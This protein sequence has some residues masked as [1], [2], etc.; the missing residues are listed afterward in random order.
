[1]MS[2]LAFKI[3]KMYPDIE[4]LVINRAF[5]GIKELGNT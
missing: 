2:V 4:Y 3:M 1:M 5:G